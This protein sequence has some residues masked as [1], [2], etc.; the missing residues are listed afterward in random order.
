[1]KSWHAFVLGFLR[2]NP[3]TITHPPNLPSRV[4]Q[5][6]RHALQAR[7]PAHLRQ[8]PWRHRA[9]GRGRGWVEWQDAVLCRAKEDCTVFCYEFRHA[10]RPLLAMKPTCATIPCPTPTLFITGGAAVWAHPGPGPGPGAGLPLR[11]P[12][13]VPLLRAAH[14]L[15][16]VQHRCGQRWRAHVSLDTCKKEAPLCTLVSNPHATQSSASRARW[17]FWR[18]SFDGSWRVPGQRWCDV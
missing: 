18:S 2:T 17:W 8:V 16:G 9:R 12:G 11:D 3:S 1:M 13:R 4:R 15:R 5:P 10:L 7:A 6:V 14:A